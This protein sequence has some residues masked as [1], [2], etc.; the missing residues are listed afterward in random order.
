M[1]S[2]ALEDIQIQVEKRMRRMCD[3]RSLINC[4]QALEADLDP[5]TETWSFNPQMSPV[6][7]DMALSA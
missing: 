1:P 3:R 7:E 4:L 6:D 2:L 5:S